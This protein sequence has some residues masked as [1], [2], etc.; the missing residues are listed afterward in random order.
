MTL[1]EAIALLR[2]KYEDAVKLE[3][4]RNPVNYALYYTWRETDKWTERMNEKYKAD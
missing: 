3:Y 4:V 2:Q 1:D